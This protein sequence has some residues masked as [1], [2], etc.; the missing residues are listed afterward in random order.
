[1]HTHP[2]KDTLN[3]ILKGRAKFTTLKGEE[4]LYPGDWRIIK[5]GLIHQTKNIGDEAL[6]ILEI[7]SPP[8]KYDLIRI[9]DVYNRQRKGYE[10]LLG[11]K[12]KPKYKC[13]YQSGTSKRLF[14]RR[15]KIKIN[16]SNF[17]FKV[18]TC[19]TSEMIFNTS[20]F[21][22]D[23]YIDVIKSNTITKILPGTFF[24]KQY[25]S[26]YWIKKGT[27]FIWNQNKK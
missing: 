20:Y 16:E 7:E 18:S 24:T 23:G 21:L 3:L 11:V 17:I 9:K 4:F 15:K 5:A 13:M 8:N 12:S 6:E 19:I 1:M 27:L 10:T 25:A 14:L 22:L 26:N 2:S